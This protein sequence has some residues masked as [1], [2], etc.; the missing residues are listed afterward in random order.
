MGVKSIFWAL[1]LALMAGV[2]WHYR[3]AQVLQSLIHPL[4]RSF[5]RAPVDDALRPDGGL[6]QKKNGAP[7]T[8]AVAGVRKCLIG[9]RVEY[10]DGGC[11]PG[12]RESAVRGGS[13]TVL[14]AQRPRTLPGPDAA[15]SASTLRD[16][17]VKPGEASL[18]EKAIE[19]IK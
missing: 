3:D 6:D 8:K 4:Q 13:L 1:L 19:Q 9:S 18:T 15:A 10:T 5:Q 7:S 11:P 17:V 16:L 12:S 14:E 2:A